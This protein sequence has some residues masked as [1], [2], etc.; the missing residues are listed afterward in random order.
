MNLRTFLGGTGAALLVLLLQLACID[1]VEGGSVNGTS[2]YAFDS[3]TGKVMV[4]GDVSK[5]YETAPAPSGEHILPTPD[6]TIGGASLDQVKE[7]GWGGLA[8][9]TSGNRLYVVSEAGKV[10]RIE[11]VRSQNGTLSSLTEIVLFT[12]GNSSDRLGSGSIFG[13]AAVDPANGTLY[14]TE[15]TDTD[16]R[17]W[18]VSNAGAVADGTT[19]PLSQIRASVGTDSKGTGVAAAQGMVYGYFGGGDNITNLN[20]GTSYSG[21]RIRRGSGQSFLASSSVL[22]YG[23]TR[24]GV[25]GS[26]ALDTSNNLLFLLRRTSDMAGDPP[27]VAYK[28][29]SFT[30]GFDQPWDFTLGTAVDHRN[31]RFLAHPG[32]KDW[33]AA[34]EMDGTSGAGRLWLWKNP[35]QA[36]ALKYFDLNGGQ[37]KGFALDGSN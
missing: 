35:S 15:T 32:N 21:A 20:T 16:A 13:Q 27:I 19:V 36:G 12:L 10:V 24:L 2:L 6:R 37:F 31:L 33:L 14:V 26:L 3:A 17:I 8:M 30:S 25:S 23:D 5:V 22:V 28:T 9:D 29:G 11:R 7:L 1:P 34:G 4:W 18:V